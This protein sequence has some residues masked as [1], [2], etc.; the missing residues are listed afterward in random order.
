MKPSTRECIVR[1]QDLHRFL[2]TGARA[3][4][5]MSETAQ[6]LRA[7]LSLSAHEQL[8]QLIHMPLQDSDVLT[9]S[10]FECLSIPGL[11]GSREKRALHEIILFEV[12]L[13]LGKHEDNFQFLFAF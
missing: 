3:R 5:V 10:G 2:I 13:I 8:I 4:L 11:G 7:L 12:Q 1:V 6:R 9:P